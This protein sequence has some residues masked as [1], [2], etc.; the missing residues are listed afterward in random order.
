[1]ADRLGSNRGGLA[2]VERV[3]NIAAVHLLVGP[4][5]CRL[6]HADTVFCLGPAEHR[7]H[8]GTEVVPPPRAAP[9]HQ[10]MRGKHRAPHTD[11][12]SPSH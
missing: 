7:V 1:M 12:E 4:G 9:L 2:V 8:H 3:I 10:R 5:D 6:K 11:V